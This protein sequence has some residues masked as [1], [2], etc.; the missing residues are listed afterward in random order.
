MSKILGQPRYDYVTMRKGQ[1]VQYDII[2]DELGLKSGCLKV[3]M[4]NN[5]HKFGPKEELIEPLVIIPEE[6][7]EKVWE[8]VTE[9]TIIPSTVLLAWRPDTYV[10]TMIIP[11][12]GLS[13]D[14]LIDEV[15]RMTSSS[16]FRLQDEGIIDFICE[17]EDYYQY[18]HFHE[19]SDKFY[20]GLPGECEDEV[21]PL[22]EDESFIPD[23]DITGYT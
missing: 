7:K 21:V 15:G 17:A 18:I 16:H 12:E 13:L 23:S 19:P 1:G 3:W 2:E 8:D 9:E 6:P 11:E 14:E 10:W 5:K 4:C 22:V 20:C